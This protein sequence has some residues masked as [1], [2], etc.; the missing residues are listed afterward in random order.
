MGTDLPGIDFVALATGLGC[1]GVRVSDASRLGGV[2]AEALA[3]GSPNLVE[4]R[5]A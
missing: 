3:S 4:V 5:V 1:P 2:L